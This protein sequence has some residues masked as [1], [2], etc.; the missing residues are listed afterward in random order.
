MSGLD[1]LT[2]AKLL[3]HSDVK[4]TQVYAHLAQDHLRSQA[5]QITF[6][7]HVIVGTKR[8]QTGEP[9]PQ[10]TVLEQLAL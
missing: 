6:G 5:D 3:G 2:V 7:L 10:P 9:Q 4:T 8:S 1:L